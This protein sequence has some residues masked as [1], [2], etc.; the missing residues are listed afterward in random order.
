M[1]REPFGLSIESLL[2]EMLNCES[3]ARWPDPAYTCKQADS[4]DR[5]RVAP[6]QPD[7]FV[8]SCENFVR[9]DEVSGRKVHVLLDVDGPG[10]IV[11]FF[12]TSHCGKPGNLRI[13]LDDAPAPVLEYRAL[14][15]LQGT[16]NPGAPLTTT[17]PCYEAN[18]FGGTV[19]YLPI[20][21]A[22]KCKVTWEEPDGG[23]ATP[24]VCYQIN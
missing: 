9:V 8:K 22:R 1:S 5:R 4:M 23:P 6:D 7:W 10:A 17:Q 15:L 19:S 16:F 11:R 2:E 20:P 18:K 13:Y 24:T 3:V 14:D 21:Y 12:V